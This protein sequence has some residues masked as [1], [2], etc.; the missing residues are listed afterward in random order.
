MFAL[1]LLTILAWHTFCMS[2]SDVPYGFRT[3]ILLSTLHVVYIQNIFTMLIT[4]LMLHH[5][6]SY[7]LSL[8]EQRSMIFISKIC[9]YCEFEPVW[10]STHYA[11]MFI[12]FYGIHSSP[13]YCSAQYMFLTAKTFFNAN[14]NTYATWYPRL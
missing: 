3:L 14:T 5:T 6:L 2:V 1:I 4:I 9:W 12:R 13:P 7:R 11:I 8:P 10:S